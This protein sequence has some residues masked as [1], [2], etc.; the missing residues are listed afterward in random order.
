MDTTGPLARFL[1]FTAL[2]RRAGFAVAP[3]QTM[4]W[5]AAIEL[6]GPS[7]VGDIRRAARATL[8][9]QP[10]RIAEFDALFDAHFLG[11]LGIGSESEPDEDEPLRAAED[12]SVGAEPVFGEDVSES[13]SRATGAERLAA[14]HFAPGGELE[15]LRRFSR[16]LPAHAPRRRGYRWRAGRGGHE[17]DAR[18]MLRDAMR[19]AGEFVRLR[20]RRRRARQRRIVLLIDISGSMKERTDTHLAFA[21]ALT[22][23]A[24]TA[25]VFTMGTR[26]TRITRAL[27]LRDREKRSPP[28]LVSW[29]I[30]MG[31]PA[32][33]RRSVPSS[34]FH[35]SPPW[36]AGQRW[37]CS[38]MVSSGVTRARCATRW[39]AS[40]ALPGV[41][42]G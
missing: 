41:P 40:P 21:H 34:P 24:E 14:R 27:R 15:T 35:A 17:T 2:L 8:A 29:P 6:L 7:E 38:R 3:E 32:S 31:A 20:Y 12:S 25:E 28:P 42:S 22:R 10:E 37:S 23:A 13:G 1:E 9:P 19:N 5:L 4:A 39:R 18:R 36:R 33:V 30:G 16:A 11:A 26:L